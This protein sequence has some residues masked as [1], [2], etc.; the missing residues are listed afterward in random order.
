MFS[1]VETAIQRSEGGLGIGLALVKGLVALH[2]GSVHAR[3]DGLGLGS[4][5]AIH[6]PEA[7]I[8]EQQPRHQRPSRHV[9]SQGDATARLKVL[10]A[11]DNRDAADSLAMLLQ[12][13]GHE[14]F[15]ATTGRQALELARRECPDVLM[16]DIGMPELSGYE[17]A[18]AVRDCPWGQ[19]ALL[20]ALTGWGQQD[21]IERARSAGFD[22]HYTKPIDT[23]AI[24]ALLAAHA[25]QGTRRAS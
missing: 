16:L 23:A 22:R 12:L 18:R 9:T 15:V 19:S 1:Q 17:V 13:S 10:V 3:S 4:S 25:R 8:V 21:D 7:C 20:I 2:G 5:F 24:E 14:V 11:D 6:L